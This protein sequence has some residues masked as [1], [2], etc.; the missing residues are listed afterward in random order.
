MEKLSVRDLEV[1]GRRVLVRVD[2]NVRTE[3]RDGNIRTT[4]DTRIRE[5]VEAVSKALPDRGVLLVE[6]VRFFREEEAN[7]DSFAQAL[8]K[9]GDVYVND[10]FGAAHRAHASTLGVAKYLPRAAM[11]LLMECEPRYL[12]DETAPYRSAIGIGRVNIRLQGTK[13]QIWKS[14][15]ESA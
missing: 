8:A 1:K 5:S 3:E 4:D 11:G 12:K 7:A 13:I 10:A 6:N 15:E 14:A 2:F 9:L